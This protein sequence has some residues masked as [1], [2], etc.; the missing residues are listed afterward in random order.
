[1]G[2]LNIVIAMNQPYV[3]L[4]NVCICINEVDINS[5]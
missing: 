5:I 3:C 4:I 1:M 2:I